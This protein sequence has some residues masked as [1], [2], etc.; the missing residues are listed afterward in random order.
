VF[1]GHARAGDPSLANAS[2]AKQYWRDSGLKNQ[3]ACDQGELVIPTLLLSL[4]VALWAGVSF[5][6]G[7]RPDACAAVTIFPTWAWAALGL[8]LAALGVRRKSKRPAALVAVLWVVSL[9]IMAEEPVSLARAAFGQAPSSELRAPRESGSLQHGAR[10]T[11][12][13]AANEASLLRV[14]SL[15]CAGGNFEAAAEVA[16]FEPDLVLLQESPSRQEVERLGRQLFHRADGALWGVDA[17]ILARG[18]LTA[19]ATPP[20]LRITCVQAHVQLASGLETDVVSLRLIP[21]LVRTDLWSPGCWRDQTANRL[22]RRD[23]LRAIVQQIDALPA[24]APLV[25]GGDFNAPAGDA[26]FRLLS[27][28]LHDTFREAGL[29]WG[30]TIINE[31]PLVRIDQVWA[32]RQ[33]QAVAVRAQRTQHSDHRMVICDLLLRKREA[34]STE[35]EASIGAN[36]LA[37]WPGG[38]RLH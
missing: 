21:A 29:G 35:H 33:F 24:A 4:S 31:E 22:A 13:G 2:G 36:R 18:H 28:R 23:Q 14:V 7:L 1:R 15:N 30:D 34:R 17:S 12:L 26:V 3:D 8:L 32:S 37:A 20:A 5:C 6:Y 25:L 16:R 11:E 27:P 9:L 19:A 38:V 10:R